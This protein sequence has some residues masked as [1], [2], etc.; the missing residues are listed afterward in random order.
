LIIYDLL[1][2]ARGTIRT[3]LFKITPREG[4]P[5][6]EEIQYS[7]DYKFQEGY[8]FYRRGAVKAAVTIDERFN[9]I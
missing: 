7:I 5:V 6:D 9:A 4:F 1:Y 8:I 3:I 2:L